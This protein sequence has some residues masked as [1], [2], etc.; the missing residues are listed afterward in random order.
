MIEDSKDKALLKKE[1]DETWALNPT[2]I[3]IWHKEF[4]NEFI[5]D[6]YFY[7]V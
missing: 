1:L 2:H 3:L 6:N 4:I 7:F 5:L